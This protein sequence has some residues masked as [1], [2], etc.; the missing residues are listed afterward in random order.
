MSWEDS[1]YTFVGRREGNNEGREDRWE[2]EREGKLQ[3]K[4]KRNSEHLLNVHNIPGIVLRGIIACMLTATSRDKY[5][6]HP[7][8]TG[9][10]SE[11]QI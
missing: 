5:S 9:E 7:H 8:F 6:Y 11:T 2:D 4:E 10:D 3:E 1:Q